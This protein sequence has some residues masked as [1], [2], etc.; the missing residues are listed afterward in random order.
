MD[1]ALARVQALEARLA[2]VEARPVYVPVPYVQP[3][4]T[5]PYTTW[6]NSATTGYVAPADKNAAPS[7]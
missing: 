7:V 1:E 6:N 4:Q 3:Y 2:A 5:F